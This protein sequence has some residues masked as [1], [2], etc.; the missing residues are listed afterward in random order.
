MNKKIIIIG[1]SAEILELAEVHGGFDILG[2]IDNF[3]KDKNYNGYP[4]LGKDDAATSIKNEYNDAAIIIPFDNIKKK[5]ALYEYYISQL[6]FELASL[7]SLRAYIS[8]R[9]RL[10]KGAIVQDGA[11]VGP[12]T[13]TGICVKINTCANVTHDCTF[14]NFSTISPNVVT[15]GYMTVGKRVFIGANA[16]ILPKLNISADTV[17]GAGSIITKDIKDPGT[18]VGN[19]GKL[20]KK[21]E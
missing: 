1:V 16:T 17:I 8:P 18:Y 4:I 14:G 10:G 5:E 15:L 6:G 20:L 7:I 12:N 21:T 3:Y 19:P 9:S 2:I 13:Q 11:Y